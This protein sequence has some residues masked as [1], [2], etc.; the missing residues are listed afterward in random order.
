[1]QITAN[2]LPI[3]L[4]AGR[5]ELPRVLVE[6]FKSQKRPYIVLAFKGQTDEEF[7]Q[8]LPHVWV[9]FGEVGKALKCF[10]DYHIKEIVAAGSMTRPTL[11]EIRPDWEG[12]KWLGKLGKKALGDDNLLKF[13]I[14]MVEVQ[15]YHVVGPTDILTELLAP[16]GLLTSEKLDDQAW[17]DIGRGIEVL[18]ALSPADVGQ[19]VVVQ[20]GLVLGVE[21]IEGTDGLIERVAPLKRSGL[22]GVL[23]KVAKRQ[24]ENRV[25]LPTVGLRTVQ[26]ALK[27]G[28]R[29]IAIEA[30]RTL[31]L[32]REE[33]IKLAQDKG[34]F[35]V[36]L[37]SAQCHPEC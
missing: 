17:Q 10:K 20:E 24:Q 5:G 22:G 14:E 30:G 16:E 4:L 25:D 36:G 3:A 11:S 28:L 12:L 1:M 2:Q 31:I 27:S 19:A 21:A 33:M 37:A 15:G 23:V 29:G 8:D 34:I 32:N 26:N 9:S 6:V 13:L 18:S 35:V 7:V